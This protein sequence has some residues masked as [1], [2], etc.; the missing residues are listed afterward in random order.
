MAKV[1]VSTFPFCRT[2]K[3]A[4]DVLQSNG[5]EVVINPLGRK[6]KPSEVLDH[7]RDF[8]ALIAGTEDLTDLVTNSKSLKLISRVG[9]GLDSVPLEL[10]RE[11][12]VAVAY[13]PDAVSPAVSELALSLIVDAMRKVTYADREIRKG[14]WTRPYGE[15]IGGAT[16]G[17]LGFGRIGKRVA[18]HLLGYLPKEILVCD[19]LDQKDS[20]LLLNELASNL[21]QVNR[22]LGKNWGTTTIKQVS[23]ESLLKKSDAITIHVPLTAE[24]KNLINYKNMALMK[25]NAVLINTARGG[26][27]N[28]N[29][30]FNILKENLI[31]AAAMDVFEEEPYKGPLCELENVILTQHMGSCS[32]DCREDMERE[33]AENVVGFFSGGRWERVV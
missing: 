33:A 22:G 2:S 25:P 29:D 11:K 27:V 21:S 5:H 18:S 30:L 6:M 26:I 23:L 13:T 19:L 14:E 8:D 24:T 28:E 15:R 17:I 3:I 32:N 4:F 20:I 1:F 9:V 10:C 31:S 16:I 12:E 7:A